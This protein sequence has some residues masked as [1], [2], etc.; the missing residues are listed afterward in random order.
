[1]KVVKINT[2][3]THFYFNCDNFKQK[4][5]TILLNTI[6]GGR[7]MNDMKF[8]G[9]GLITFDEEND[10]PHRYPE[11]RFLNDDGTPMQWN[12]KGTNCIVFDLPQTD[13][14]DVYDKLFLYHTNSKNGQGVWY[15]WVAYNTKTKVKSHRFFVDHDTQDLMVALNRFFYRINT[16]K[17]NEIHLEESRKNST[18]N[19][20]A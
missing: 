6:A 3:F 8:S 14:N 2:E 17:R 4:D 12:R 1:M 16:V 10:L 9:Y 15:G 19:I 5:T 11:I 13:K 7:L 18:R 20:A